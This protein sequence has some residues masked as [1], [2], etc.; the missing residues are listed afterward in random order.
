MSPNGGPDPALTETAL[1]RMLAAETGRRAKLYET[2]IRA[3]T[4]TIFRA[5]GVQILAGDDTVYTIGSH[6]PLTQTNSS[7]PLG[8]LAGAE[9]MVTD[10]SH[11]RINGR[12]MLLPLALTALA[13]MTMADAAVVFPDGTVHAHALHGNSE[14]CAAQKQVVRFNA[15]AGAATPEAT[16]LDHGHVAKLQNLQGLRAAGLLN[17][18]EYDARRAEIISSF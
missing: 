16:R 2:F 17:Q 14:V 15:L 9:A 6:D 3:G 12:A 18:E 7:R 8:L 4:A 5:L 10:G 1:D 13:T 11:V